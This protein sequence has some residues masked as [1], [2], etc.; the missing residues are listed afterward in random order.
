MGRL[1]TSLPARLTT[2]QGTR[3]ATL[4]DLSLAGAR[5]GAPSDLAIFSGIGLK[6]YV[7]IEWNRFEAFGQLVWASADRWTGTIGM[8]FDGM[9]APAV[10]LATRDLQDEYV[11]LGGYEHDVRERARNWVRGAA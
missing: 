3:P 10:L 8:K 7:L 4:A 11:R 5:I 1:A 9:I 2:L 6:A